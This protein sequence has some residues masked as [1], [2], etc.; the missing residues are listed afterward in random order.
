MWREI[1]ETIFVLTYGAFAGVG[2]MTTFLCFYRGGVLELNIKKFI[3]RGNN[4]LEE[5]TSDE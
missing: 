3:D 5:V 4:D 1:V 2:I